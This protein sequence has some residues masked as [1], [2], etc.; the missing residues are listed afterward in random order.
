VT[1]AVVLGAVLFVA[2][3]AV[4]VRAAVVCAERG[5]L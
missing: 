1:A 3:L 2:A 4:C 5:W